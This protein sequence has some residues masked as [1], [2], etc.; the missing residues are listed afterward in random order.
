M[1]VLVTCMRE[2]RN[3][4]GM[5]WCGKQNLPRQ[6]WN[7]QESQ[8]RQDNGKLIAWLVQHRTITAVQDGVMC[9]YPDW[10]TATILLLPSLPYTWTLRF[11]LSTRTFFLACNTSV[12]QPRGSGETRRFY[13]GFLTAR[14]MGGRDTRSSF[15]VCS[16]VRVQI[17]TPPEQSPWHC[18]QRRPL[19][20]L[21]VESADAVIGECW[22]FSL[23]CFETE[24][25]HNV[26]MSSK[27][28]AA[29]SRSFSDCTS[30]TVPCRWRQ[31]HSR[32]AKLQ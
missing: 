17:L 13:L 25:E 23:H 27:M 6:W 14:A 4:A 21:A 18:R 29:V 28:I 9:V 24:L 3:M 22:Y 2:N 10:Q 31:E 12:K 5:S 15:I 19:A 1:S 30:V 11:L 32:K 20:L 8:G 7:S 26:R 16:D